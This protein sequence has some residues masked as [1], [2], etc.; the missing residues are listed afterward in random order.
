MMGWDIFLWTEGRRNA[1]QILVGKLLEHGHL[2]NNNISLI[3]EI[4]ENGF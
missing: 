2:E 4:L 1:Y 3:K